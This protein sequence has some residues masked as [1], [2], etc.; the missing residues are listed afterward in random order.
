MSKL[1]KK[2]KAPNPKFQFPNKSQAPNYKTPVI[3]GRDQ[4]VQGL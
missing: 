3:P 2:I 1:F 4:A